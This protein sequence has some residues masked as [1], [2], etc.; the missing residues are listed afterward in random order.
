MTDEQRTSMQCADHCSHMGNQ[1]HS[2]GGGV[3]TRA[4]FT[5]SAGRHALCSTLQHVVQGS[6]LPQEGCK[7]AFDL[8]CV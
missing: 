5:V 6:K 4:G 7:K 3:S 8:Q 1:Y 2:R